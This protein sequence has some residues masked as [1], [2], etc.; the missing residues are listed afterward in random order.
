VK[1]ALVV[2]AVVV[3]AGGCTGGRSADPAP[4]PQQG[5]AAAVAK[6]RATNAKFS[7]NISVRGKATLTGLGY[8]DE[9]RQA[10]LA[11][12]NDTSGGWE[13]FALGSDLY[14][15]LPP[16][17]AGLQP[18]KYTHID[19]SR[20]KSVAPLGVDPYDPGGIGRLPDA[21]VSVAK[22]KDG[23]YSGSVDLAKATPPGVTPDVLRQLGSAAG[24]AAFEA[25]VDQAGRLV[26]VTIH[27]SGPNFGA[28]DQTYLSFDNLG[29]K[30]DE[31]FTPPG[32]DAVV[33]ASPQLY[34][35]LGG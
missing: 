35:L 31:P 16:S 30:L 11:H 15:R 21:V 34:T 6:T 17:T 3:L 33:E 13:T 26:S 23:N 18:H 22:R 14:V 1:S 25:T 12:A 2:A 27:L 24:A 32:A 4:S 5:L 19:G 20:V 28:R 10:T 9:N 29:G 8:P 7:F